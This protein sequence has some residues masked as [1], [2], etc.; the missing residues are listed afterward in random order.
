MEG[1]PCFHGHVAAQ[2]GRRRVGSDF[3]EAYASAFSTRTHCC[4]GNDG[5]ETRLDASIYRPAR[6]KLAR[7]VFF[8]IHPYHQIGGYSPPGSIVVKPSI[9]STPGM[10]TTPAQE[11]AV[12]LTRQIDNLVFLLQGDGRNLHERTASIQH[13]L[14]HDELQELRVIADMNYKLVYSEE[15]GLGGDQRQF[16][17]TCHWLI[18]RLEMHM[19]TRAQLQTNSASL[20]VR[21][22]PWLFNAWA[23]Q[24]M[25]FGV[26]VACLL[27]LAFFCVHT[28]ELGGWSHNMVESLTGLPLIV[29][30][31]L[32]SITAA[33]YA[34]TQLSERAYHPVNKQE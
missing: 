19:E 23:N 5:E 3:W 16:L 7:H 34:A 12:E 26:E 14:K 8:G 20:T 25:A 29:F 30:S 22:S 33:M 28:V 2:P 6:T 21:K 24:C 13:L 32:M 11:S 1:L 18:E 4:C 17:D 27:V 10:I 9:C 15:N 31:V